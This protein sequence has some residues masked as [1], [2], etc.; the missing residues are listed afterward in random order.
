MR[1][2]TKLAGVTVYDPEQDLDGAVRD[3]F[4]ED[5]FISK[6]RG[7]ARCSMPFTT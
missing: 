4:V 7:W 2:L 1:M 6:T 5:S 3:I